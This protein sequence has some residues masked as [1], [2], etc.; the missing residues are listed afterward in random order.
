M[1]ATFL[2]NNLSAVELFPVLKYNLNSF[3]K[4]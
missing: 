1:E 3:P 4:Q 2:K